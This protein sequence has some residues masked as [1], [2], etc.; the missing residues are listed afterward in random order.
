MLLP[1]VFVWIGGLIWL[2]RHRH[3]QL[4]ALTYVFVIILLMLGSGKSYYSLG[5]YPM[6]LGAGGVWL[7]RATARRRILRY[8]AV[9]VILLLA[10]P[11]VPII[12]PMQP[13][14]VMAVTNQKYG[15]EKLGILKWED[16]QTH[17]LQ[18]DFADMQ[19]WRELATK[20]ERVFNSLP[21]TEQARTVVFCRHYGQAS[22]LKYY[23]KGKEFRSKVFTDNGTFLL[24]IPDS[25]QFDH[26]LF[27]GRKMP[28]KDD[29]VFQHFGKVT[30][31]DSVN[32]PLSR[33]HG[34]KIIFFERADSLAA[35]LANAGLKDMKRT[36]GH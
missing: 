8:G 5:T 31:L 19:G 12:M 29:E 15:L 35:K 21:A 23:A 20:S 14:A 10:L 3:Y 6:L 36:F 9:A 32:N 28:D 25:L 7:E 16:Q 30:L 13:P 27:I 17:A 11:F 1:V 34:D 26:L 33:Q 18:Q 24:W 2:F 22:A 4:L